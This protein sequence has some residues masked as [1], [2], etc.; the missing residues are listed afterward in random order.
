MSFKEI[1]DADQSLKN[2]LFQFQKLY[3]AQKHK[4]PQT[5]QI[6]FLKEMQLVPCIEVLDMDK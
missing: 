5:L 3:L 6:D 1:Q 2:L 4:S